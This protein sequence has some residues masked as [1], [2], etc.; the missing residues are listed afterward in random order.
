MARLP[1][2]TALGDRPTPVSRRG[3][4]QAADDGGAGRAVQRFAAELGEKA[5][6]FSKEDDAQAVFAARRKLD[7]W[8]R[9]AIF[10]PEKGAAS[11]LGKDALDLPK[12]IPQSFDDFAGKVAG[13]LTSKRQRLAF[14]QVAESR[15]AQ[16][17]D[18]AGRHALAQKKSY[19]EGQYQADIKSFGDRAAL[20]PDKAGV[21]VAM[22]RE[23]TIGYLRGQG[24]SEEEIQAVVKENESRIHLQVMSGMLANNDGEAAKAYF[25]KNKAGM[26]ADAIL[27]A[28]R[29]MKEVVARGKAQAFGDMA[30][31]KG[32]TAAE[33][34]AEARRKFSGPE[35]VA[36]V[37]EVKTRFAEREALKAAEQKQSSDEAWKIITNGGSRKGIKPDLWN[38]LSGDEQRQINDYTEARW[39]RAKADAEGREI[40]TDLKAYADILSLPP[41][42]FVGLRLDAFQDRISRSDLKSLMDK[43]EKLREPK[44]ATDVVTLDQQVSATI[45]TL[46]L[47][48][49]KD[50]EKKGQLQHAIYTALESELRGRGGKKLTQAERQSII[51]KQIIEVTVPDSGWF[52]DDKK[53][54]YLLTPEERAKVNKA[55]PGKTVVRTG[56][57]NGRKVVQHSDGSVEY[58]D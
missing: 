48:G 15:R 24:R 11:K 28:E 7:E 29:D 39:R 27:H 8:E 43:Q 56:T 41:D 55:K 37:N 25:D 58:A 1:D 10:D 44:E 21:E 13:E 17:S 51:D 47:S 12:T 31:E 42:Q 5:E 38:R 4:V 33:A 6:E 22:Q 45:N 46:G 52:R 30:V 32:M 35:E 23:R 54:A 14:Q 50:Q 53:P 2:V 9:A 34:L 3:F 40:K 19:D 16:V 36:A 49:E 26:S 20:F 18:W 57:L